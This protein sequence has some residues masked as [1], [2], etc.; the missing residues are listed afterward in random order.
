MYFSVSVQY[1]KVV[2]LSLAGPEVIKQCHAEQSLYP[3]KL[4]TTV[5]C[6]ALKRL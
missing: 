5:F 4:V 2:V 1:I 6:L 3:L